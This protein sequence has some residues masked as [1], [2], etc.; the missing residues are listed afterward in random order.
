MKFALLCSTG[1]LAMTTAALPARAMPEIASGD[2]M[3][4]TGVEGCLA[5]A[6][7]FMQGLE[8]QMSR[9]EIDRTGYFEDGVFRIL[10]YPNP[11]QAESPGAAGTTDTSLAV[12][13]ASHDSDPDVASSFVQVALDAMGN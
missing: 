12:I 6:D 9:G 5:Q 2:R 3:L 4:E 7:N 1:L 13:F 10:C 8:V 11:Y